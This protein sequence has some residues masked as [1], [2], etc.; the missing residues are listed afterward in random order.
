M[1][2]RC[3]GFYCGAHV[4]ALAENKGIEPLQTFSTPSRRPCDEPA[5]R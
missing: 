3:Q 4:K 1:N 2:G 5:P